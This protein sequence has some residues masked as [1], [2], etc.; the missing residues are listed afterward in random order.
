MIKDILD[1]CAPNT[2]G[3]TEFGI[4]V[5]SIYLKA[6][7]MG[8][9]VTDTTAVTLGVYLYGPPKAEEGSA[10]AFTV[11]PFSRVSVIVYP[12]S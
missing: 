3:A 7:S 4:V 5:L 2:L 12:F 10:I 1:H 11:Y 6:E 9:D 8:L